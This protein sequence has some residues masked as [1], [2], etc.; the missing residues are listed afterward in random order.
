VQRPYLARHLKASMMRVRLLLLLA[1]FLLLG[2]GCT[3][4]YAFSANKNKMGIGNYRFNGRMVS[5]WVDVSA[6][7]IK[8]SFESLVGISI[9]MR[10]VPSPDGVILCYHLTITS[11]LVSP[12]PNTK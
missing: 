10:T 5:C 3:R 1:L 4:K 6:G 2:Q 8:S 7:T 12:V 11:L 9:S